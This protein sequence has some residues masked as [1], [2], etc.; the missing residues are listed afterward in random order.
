MLT[1][2]QSCNLCL[3]G[4]TSDVTEG[5]SD[6]PAAAA[7]KEASSAREPHGTID[8]STRRT[9][10][11]LNL[12]SLGERIGGDSGEVGA[13]KERDK[14]R[15]RSSSFSRLSSRLGARDCGEISSVR[16]YVRCIGFMGRRCMYVYVRM[17]VC[18]PMVCN[19]SG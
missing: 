7:S 6:A 8:A 3:A 15:V 9:R 2:V 19:V 4:S 14:I 17:H 12:Q 1:R 11:W 10:S 16:L 18:L 13:E 5:S